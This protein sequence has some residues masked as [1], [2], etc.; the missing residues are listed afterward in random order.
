MWGVREGRAPVRICVSSGTSG[1]QAGSGLVTTAPGMARMAPITPSQFT[2]VL[3]G[4]MVWDEA[5]VACK[6]C[7]SHGKTRGEKKR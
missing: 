5:G 6:L 1:P 2:T 3:P 4:G 7:Q